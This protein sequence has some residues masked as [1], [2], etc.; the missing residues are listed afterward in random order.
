M[1]N[2][3]FESAIYEIIKD[4][5]KNDF[6][7]YCY[8]IDLFII[9]EPG[10]AE[11]FPEEILYYSAHQKRWSGKLREIKYTNDL[12]VKEM[13]SRTLLLSKRYL[14]KNSYF[15]IKPNNI[16]S[17]SLPS[18]NDRLNVIL[19]KADEL[20]QEIF[21]EIENNL[22]FKAESQIIKSNM[23]QGKIDWNTTILESVH[24]GSSSPTLFTCLRNETSF[25]LAENILAVL[26][27]MHLQ[28]DIIA[29][30]KSTNSEDFDYDETIKI[31]RYEQRINQLLYETNLHEVARKYFDY[32]YLPL[33]SRKFSVLLQEAE[34]RY[35]RGLV[36]NKHYRYL[37][38]WIKEYRY[39]NV[40][41]LGKFFTKFP[42]EHEETI[43]TMYELWIIFEMISYFE[44]EQNVKIG[45][46]IKNSEGEFRGFK[47]SFGDKDFELL[48]QKYITDLPYG[49]AENPDFI[50]KI[51][52]KFPI[53]MDPKN[54]RGSHGDAIHTMLAYL[55]QLQH[56]YGTKYGILFFSTRPSFVAT[57]A[58]YSKHKGQN[59]QT[60]YFYHNIHEV[61]Q[62]SLNEHYE[63]IF[64]AIKNELQAS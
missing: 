39:L 1:T 64:E 56:T 61:T 12:G 14:G 38:D 10:F 54:Y 36:R 49:R 23:I 50:I 25:D 5:S 40:A 27:L 6:N 46:Q 63:I 32:R 7:S 52:N 58:T 16:R 3:S 31:K 11:K 43:D 4:K 57:P 60:Y 51:E 47:L 59:D 62:E 34:T 26:C 42:W 2:R 41:S 19:E 22:D 55:H 17:F 18:K 48:Y 13:L 37:I 35:N 33:T 30:L 44:H 15:E 20:I 8:S 9:K 45:E 21:P 24:T 28:D 29:L 53:I